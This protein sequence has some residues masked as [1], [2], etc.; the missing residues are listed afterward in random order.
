[1]KLLKNRNFS[2]MIIGQ[3]ISLFGNSILRFSI[4]L[5]I[6]DQTGSA[7]I[8]GSILAISILPTIFLSPIGGIMADRISRKHIML[9][10]D[11]LTSFLILLFSMMISIG[12]HMILM[13]AVVMVLLSIIQACYQPSVQSS[14]PLLVNEDDLM[15][16]N[17]LVVQI[18]ALSTLLGPILGGFLYALMTFSH[19]LWIAAGCFLFSAIIECIMKIPYQKTTRKENLIKSSWS[20]MKEGMH[21]ITHDHPSLFKLLMILA[22]LNLILSSFFTVGLP[23]ISNITLGLPAQYYGYLEAGIAVGSI[24]GSIALAVLFKKHTIATSYRFLMFASF[25]ITVIAIA[26]CF[27]DTPYISY[28]MILLSSMISMAAAT[29][30]NILAQTFMQQCTPS[31]LLGKVTSFVTMIVMCS[32]PIG[33]AIYG[34]L[35]DTFPIHQSLIILIASILSLFLSLCTKKNLKKDL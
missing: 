8:F 20:D 29:M 11:F 27:K 17:G 24:I 21:F 33:Q 16:A 18:N 25:S 31:H 34:F 5:F 12:D 4:S 32:Y 3:I 1:M 26:L 9:V 14:V 6:L 7:T 15:K 23:V 30:F 13:I 19:L 10:L 22:A 35:F 28:G 2:L